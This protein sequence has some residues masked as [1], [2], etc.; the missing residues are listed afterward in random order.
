MLDTQT[1]TAVGDGLRP[2]VTS[3]P[4]VDEGLHWSYMIQWIIFAIVGFFGLAY[5]IRTEFRRVNED[6][7]EEQAREAERVRKRARKAFTD[8]EIEDEVLDGFIPLSRWGPA[9]G[10]RV[11][12][13]QST[14]GAGDEPELK[15]IYAKDVTPK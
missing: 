1:P 9:S 6:D 7:P 8:A 2:L 11:V 10:A 15:E 4:T 3:A 14:L 5:A 13:A 12:P